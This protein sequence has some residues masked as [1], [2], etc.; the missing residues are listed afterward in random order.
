MMVGY[1]SMLSEPEMPPFMIT[2]G[3]CDQRTWETLVRAKGRK[4]LSLHVSKDPWHDKTMI[5][6]WVWDD[7][8][9]LKL[10][11]GDS[12]MRTITPMGR[13]KDKLKQLEIETLNWGGHKEFIVDVSACSSVRVDPFGIVWADT[14]KMTEVGPLS[15]ETVDQANELL[16]EYEESL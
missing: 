5:K 15:E 14:D 16:C 7:A 1:A 9:R 4:N 13:A 2:N 12:G 11:W 8:D 6:E 10:W 3:T